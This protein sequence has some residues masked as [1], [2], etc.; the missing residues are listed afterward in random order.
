MSSQAGPSSSRRAPASSGS[1]R[2]RQNRSGGNKARRPAS[3]DS[4]SRV[5]DRAPAPAQESAGDFASPPPELPRCRTEGYMPAGVLQEH[6]SGR[7]ILANYRLESTYVDPQRVDFTR[8]KHA[9]EHSAFV[10]RAIQEH[11]D[12]LLEN[13][14]P[15]SPLFPN[16]RPSSRALMVR[17]WAPTPMRTPKP[18]VSIFLERQRARIAER[19]LIRENHNAECAR[20][21]TEHLAAIDAERGEVFAMWEAER[22]A[23]EHEVAA[24]ERE[25]KKVESNLASVHEHYVDESVTIGRQLR[26]DHEIR[27]LTRHAIRVRDEASY[28]HEMAVALQGNVSFGEDIDLF[29]EAAHL[30]DVPAGFAYVPLDPANAPVRFPSVPPPNGKGKGVDPLERPNTLGRIIVKKVG[31]SSS[32]EKGKGKA[33]SGSSSSNLDSAKRPKVNLVLPPPPP[34]FAAPSSSISKKRTASEQGSSERP[35]KQSKTDEAAPFSYKGRSTCNPYA[36]TIDFPL[37]NEGI[38]PAAPADAGSWKVWFTQRLPCGRHLLRY[39]PHPMVKFPHPCGACNEKGW[40]CVADSDPEGKSASCASCQRAKTVCTPVRHGSSNGLT[41][42]LAYQGAYASHFDRKLGHIK[43]AFAA[44][45]NFDT[46]YPPDIDYRTTAKRRNKVPFKWTAA[47]AEK[48]GAADASKRKAKG[49]KMKAEPDV[50]MDGVESED[51]AE[52]TEADEEAVDDTVPP[53]AI[54]ADSSEGPTANSARPVAVSSPSRSPAPPSAASGSRTAPPRRSQF[55]YRPADLL[56]GDVDNPLPRAQYNDQH[57]LPHDDFD[58]P[59]PPDS[60]FGKMRAWNIPQE[61]YPLDITAA[62][63]QA[64]QSWNVSWFMEMS[65][66]NL[67]TAGSQFAAAL[68]RNSSPL[69][70]LKPEEPTR[71]LVVDGIPFPCPVP[72]LDSDETWRTAALLKARAYP[73]SLRFARALMDAN[74][75]GRI[76]RGEGRRVN[77]HLPSGWDI[78]DLFGFFA[79]DE[80]FIKQELEERE[81]NSLFLPGQP[82]RETR[83]DAG[84]SP[85]P[86]GP[87]PSPP[88]PD[89]V[90][91]APELGVNHRL[92]ASAGIS[93]EMI[94]ETIRAAAPRA[95][96]PRAEA[97]PRFSLFGSPGYALGGLRPFTFVPPPP[98]PLPGQRSHQPTDDEIPVE[99]G[100]RATSLADELRASSI[101]DRDGSPTPILRSPVSVKAEED[102]DGRVTPFIDN[103]TWEVDGES[104]GDMDLTDDS[105]RP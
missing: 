56:G 55:K 102:R 72:T 92:A 66:M 95:G 94:R 104:L 88:P 84:N 99:S 18:A 93:S 57:H 63:Y 105:G 12:R 101:A 89:S 85:P 6:L 91:E 2:S 21:Q 76:L 39:G 79:K 75:E 30:G 58:M 67:Y 52:E 23:L 90:S 34:D 49:G 29:F 24:Y 74:T 96:D 37:L 53:I 98:P 45:F 8:L 11:R 50:E 64:R 16:F 3:G 36:R 9:L 17:K 25:L 87:R 38:A 71:P 61:N 68:M 78:A 40:P 86:L 69:D 33:K 22:V 10:G 80:A 19:R 100:G 48:G 14:P 73:Q 43:P 27:A 83:F 54:L 51:N 41:E 103:R 32:G 97:A 46:W 70:D 15:F 5:Q 44:P 28:I 13:P 77:E 7:Q 81:G 62:R 20:I 82:L 26:R 31:A 1:S 42:F 4:V 60:C 59:V 65:R 47:A 35:S